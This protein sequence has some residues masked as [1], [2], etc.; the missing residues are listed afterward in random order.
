[1]IAIRKHRPS[2]A[3]PGPVLADRRIEV[4]GR[5]D[6]KPLHP[7]GERALVVSLHQQM[8]MIALNAQVH[9]P[10][11]LAPRRRQRGLAN[12]LVRRASAQIADRT[13]DT[14]DHVHRVPRLELGPH[15]VR[16]TRPSLGLGPG[17]FAT[18]PTLSPAPL[19]DRR[20]EQRQLLGL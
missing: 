5:R 10:E 8:Q 12:C 18:G 14:Q 1:M 6:L 16:R 9:D 7:R 11:V 4:L 19:V 13:D 3:R 2:P 20:L 15:S 17:P